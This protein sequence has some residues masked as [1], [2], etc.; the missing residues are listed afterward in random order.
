[1]YTTSDVESVAFTS[2][3]GDSVLRIQ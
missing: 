1:M 2:G 3:V